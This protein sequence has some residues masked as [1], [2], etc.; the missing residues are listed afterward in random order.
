MLKYF[1]Y[2]KGGGEGRIPI[3]SVRHHNPQS[4]SE[5]VDV[6]NTV[7]RCKEYIIYLYSPIQCDFST[8]GVAVKQNSAECRV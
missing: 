5:V 4:M 7:W 8:S 1:N 3:L 2:V 6:G